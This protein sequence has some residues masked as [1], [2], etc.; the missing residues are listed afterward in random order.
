MAEVE[1]IPNIPNEF[2]YRVSSCKHAF[3]KIRKSIYFL[4]TFISVFEKELFFQ[5]GKNN[6]AVFL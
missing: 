1:C 5:L 6:E 3:V 4:V 2:E